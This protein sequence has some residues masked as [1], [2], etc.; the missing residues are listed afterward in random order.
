MTPIRWVLTFGLVWLFFGLVGVAAVLVG[1]WLMR[2][3]S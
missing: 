2:W 1:L 3:F